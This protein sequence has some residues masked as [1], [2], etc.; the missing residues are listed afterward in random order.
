MAVLVAGSILVAPVFTAFHVDEEEK[1]PH[2]MNKDLWTAAFIRQATADDTRA[3]VETLTEAADWVE[4]LDG[5]TMW[6]EGELEEHRVRAEADA[7][8][9]VVAEIDGRV[10]GAIRFQ[11]E[12]QLFWPD[13]D[14]SDSAFVHRLAVRR[15]NA[16]QGISRALLQWAVERARLLG[17]RYLRLDCDAD[18]PRL[19][20]LYERFGFRLHSYRH[21]GAYYVS[22]YELD[23]RLKP[24][25]T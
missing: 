15:A 13:L 9:F 24:D 16:G 7:G 4:R 12:D 21:V 17:K 18:R 22:R 1:A 25:A 23:V 5:T 3:L 8:M 19:R 6:V 10:V 11:L 20:E 2:S 14:G